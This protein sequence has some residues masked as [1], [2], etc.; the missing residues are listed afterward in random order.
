MGR[1]PGNPPTPQRQVGTVYPDLPDEP[2]SRGR[3]ST[4]GLLIASGMF[5]RLVPGSPAAVY[6]GCLRL[7]LKLVGTILQQIGKVFQRRGQI[8]VEQHG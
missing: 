2:A 7:A 3:D 8:R 5:K 1:L 6:L 4:L